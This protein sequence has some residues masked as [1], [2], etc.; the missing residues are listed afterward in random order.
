MLYSVDMRIIEEDKISVAL[1]SGCLLA[2]LFWG[3]WHGSHISLMLGGSDTLI[4]IG[5]LFG[6]LSMFTL[7]LQLV[8]VGRITFIEDLWGHDKMNR[9]HRTVGYCIL[10]FFIGHAA[11][12]YLG[13]GAQTGSSFITQTKN[14]ITNWEDILNAL[15]GVLLFIVIIILSIPFVRRKL[16]Y[17][18]WYFSHLFLYVAIVLVFAHQTNSTDLIVSPLFL[19]FWNILVYG[20]IGIMLLYRFGRPLFLLYR[21]KFK[22]EKV[23]AE[24][25]NTASIYITG[26]QMNRFHFTAGQFAHL[27]FFA[28]GF[29]S[30][31]HP[32]SFSVAPNGTYVRFTPKAIG[33][34]TARIP[35]LPVGTHVLIDGPLGHFTL[36]NAHSKKYLL[37]AGGIGITPIRALMQT[38]AH[39]SG[40]MKLVW[41][42][43]SE[44][45]LVFMNEIPNFLTAIS[46]FVSKET[47]NPA[48]IPGRIT[49]ESLA[50]IAP[51]IIERDIF[52]CGPP[53]MMDA[54]QKILR[55]LGVE[56]KYIHFEKFSY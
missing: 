55:E 36:A 17:E 41:A 9:I 46:I 35:Q 51:D 33:D 16:R 48:Y 8:L 12:M 14:F 53:V 18:T 56:K 50:H 4:A 54:V 19:L 45:D 25:N 1:V 49:K 22:V 43:T 42:V 40:D 6:L 27:R 3:W 20:V 39:E 11:L 26:E 24:N 34:Y 31:S 52:L 29:W 32:F 13:Y 7:L 10:I 37:I 28:K 23:V 2:L 47:T 15:I 5:R 21:H 44:S 38:I 30:E